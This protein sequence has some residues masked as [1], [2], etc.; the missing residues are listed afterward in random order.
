MADESA[1]D[2]VSRAGF[3]AS[4]MTPLLLPRRSLITTETVSR[5]LRRTRSI[6]PMAFSTLAFGADV[7]ARCRVC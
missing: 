5:W 4:C 7:S 3:P 1:S 6:N 2:V